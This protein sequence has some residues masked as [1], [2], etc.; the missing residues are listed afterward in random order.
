MKKTV[1]ELS[2]IKREIVECVFDSDRHFNQF[3]SNTKEKLHNKK[4]AC[5]GLIFLSGVLNYQF[6]QHFFHVMDPTKIIYLV[7]YDFLK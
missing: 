6:Q 7:K 2:L 4:N 3:T 5:L 1:H